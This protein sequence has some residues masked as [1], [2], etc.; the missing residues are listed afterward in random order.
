MSQEQRTSAA[1]SAGGGEI[2]MA[3]F[4]S[5]GTTL[6]KEY[7]LKASIEAT[8]TNEPET[9]DIKDVSGKMP[10]TGDTIVSAVTTTF[11]MTIADM[12]DEILELIHAATKTTI[13]QTVATAEAVVLA[14]VNTN[15]YV[16]LG[17]YDITELVIKNDDAGSP[18]TETLIDGIDYRFVKE[19]G[20]IVPLFG[21]AIEDGDTVHASITAPA[22]TYS[23]FEALERE[24][25]FAQLR[26]VSN[27]K[28]GKLENTKFRKMSLVPSGDLVLLGETLEYRKATFACTALK[29]N[30]K[31][32]DV[33]SVEIKS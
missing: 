14:A 13:T 11:N 3:V 25:I 33:E 30:G 28:R 16:T 32:Y 2:T 27:P 23:K 8:L 19:G 1:Y 7:I 15:E 21:G 29:H 17:Y 22:G 5:D 9:I 18:G 31:I 6:G 26:F 24:Q 4:A 10:V 12:S 20:Y